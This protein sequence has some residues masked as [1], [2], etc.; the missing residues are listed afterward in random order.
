MSQ[1]GAAGRPR[2]PDGG[3]AGR[4]RIQP[5]DSRTASGAVVSAALAN[6]PRKPRMRSRAVNWPGLAWLIQVRMA[7]ALATAGSVPMLSYAAFAWAVK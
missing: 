5:W 7:R 2:P 1:V 4:W 6:L 3:G